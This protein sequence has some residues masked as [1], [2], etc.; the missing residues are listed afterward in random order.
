MFDIKTIIIIYIIMNK[1]QDRS[2]NK[3]EDDLIIFPFEGR[4]IFF[5]FKDIY[6]CFGNGTNINFFLFKI[7]IQMFY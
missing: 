7:F 6:Y 2:T 1:I 5:S 4:Y 3:V